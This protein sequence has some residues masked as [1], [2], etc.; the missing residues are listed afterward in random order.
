M[1]SQVHLNLYC[2]EIKETE[3]RDPVFGDEKWAYIGLLIVPV[4]IEAKLVSRLLD[5]RCGNPKGPKKWGTCSPPCP[6][7]AKNDKE[8]HYQKLDSMDEYF[9]GKRWLRFLLTDT[10]LTYFHILGINLGHLDYSCFGEAKPSERFGRI[11][12]RF[13]RT[14]VLKSVKSY[15]HQYETI[16]ISSVVHDRTE[17]AYGDYFPWH[18]IY[19]IDRDDKKIG[20]DCEEIKFLDSDHRTSLDPRSHLIQY[21]DLILGAAFNALHWASQD[22]NKTDI[23][24][25]MVPLLER[26]MHSPGNVN[27]RFQ[28]VGRQTIDF[29]PARRV[30]SLAERGQELGGRPSFYKIRELRVKRFLQ[31]TLFNQV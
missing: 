19:R 15:F 18:V 11:Y 5:K 4:S 6:Y 8:V 31:P 12:N 2:D 9:I 20:F 30:E 22:K 24:L 25:R 29:F 28:Y 3:I 17:M 21:T 13:F 16:I 7:H 27:S 10:C 26:L 1:P 23:A 14:A